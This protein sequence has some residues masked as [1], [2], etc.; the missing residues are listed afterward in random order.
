M[1]ITQSPDRQY[2]LEAIQHV[3]ELGYLT[4]PERR[5]LLRN[6]IKILKQSQN[7]DDQPL[8][9]DEQKEL[10]SSPQLITPKEGGLKAQV[11]LVVKPVKLGKKRP[12]RKAEYVTPRKKHWYTNGKKNGVFDK[13]SIPDG[14]RRGQVRTDRPT[15]KPV[16]RQWYNNRRFS[17]QFDVGS[18]IPK[19]YVLGR[20][21]TWNRSALRKS[22]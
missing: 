13:D 17:K 12:A 6:T 14:W 11:S 22:A 16:T 20:I 9:P 4:L 8:P 21:I 7:I 1:D 10:L 3:A 15:P 19:G 18:E 2:V 5:V